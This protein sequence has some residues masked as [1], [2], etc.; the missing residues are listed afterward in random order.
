MLS[1]TGLFVWGGLLL[2]DQDIAAAEPVEPVVVHV[3]IYLNGIE[4]LKLREN[5]FVADFYI[6]FRW[7][8][9]SVKPLESFEVANG[10]IDSKTDPY[11]G[12]RGD[13]NYA[14][15][16][17]EAT[18][19]QFWD[20]TRFPLDRQ[21][22]SI[23]IED[24]DSEAREIK[25]VADAHN[26]GVDPQ[27]R[28]PGCFLEACHAVVVPQLYKTNYVD[29]SLPPDTESA[30]SRFLFSVPIVRSGWGYFLKL[31]FGLFV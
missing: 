2:P 28:V 7:K 25:Y 3:G 6:W 12:V 5:Q 4:S 9:D 20:V 21:V 24:R 29:A 14:Y 8:G 15:Q 27:T 17:V 10:R 26:S 19:T 31:L 18:I 16:R 30:Y 1:M 22:L 13:E 23:A 11:V